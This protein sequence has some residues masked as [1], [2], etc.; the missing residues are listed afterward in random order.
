[1]AWP[2]C[3]AYPEMGAMRR[4]DSGIGNEHPPRLFYFYHLNNSFNRFLGG[5]KLFYTRL[6]CVYSIFCYLYL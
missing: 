2:V 1:M 6:P 4:P 3:I 5:I